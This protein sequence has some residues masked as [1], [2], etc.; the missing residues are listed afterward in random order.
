MCLTL[1]LKRTEFARLCYVTINLNAESCYKC[2]IAFGLHTFRRNIKFSI[3]EIL[4]IITTVLF[5][6]SLWRH[7]IANTCDVVNEMFLTI[8]KKV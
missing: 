8:A 2:Q 5:R 1:A 3:Y 4:D 7:H 6:Y